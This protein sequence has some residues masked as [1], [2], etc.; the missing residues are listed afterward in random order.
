MNNKNN[1]EPSEYL[2]RILS[3]KGTYPSCTL[4]SGG[5]HYEVIEDIPTLL[6]KYKPCAESKFNNVSEFTVISRNELKAA[7]CYILSLGPALTTFYFDNN[8]FHHQAFCL[9]NQESFEDQLKD[10]FYSYKSR[11]ENWPSTSEYSYFEYPTDEIALYKE[12]IKKYPITNHLL[13]R[14]S[15]YLLKSLMLLLD[16]F[17]M[18]DAMINVS[19]ATAGCIELIKRKH[20]NYSDAYDHDLIEIVAEKIFKYPEGAVEFIEDIYRYRTMFVHPVSKYGENWIPVHLTDDL[21]DYYEI[22]KGFFI[23]ALTK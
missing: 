12:L 3:S 9:N 17:F 21:L 6:T 19:L 15:N 11:C 20:G 10:I 14:T 7:T 13:L 2:F 23:Y 1:R 16:V 4:S 22:L 8:N 5:I 18:D